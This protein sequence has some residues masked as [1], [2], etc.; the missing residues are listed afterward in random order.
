MKKALLFLFAASVVFAAGPKVPYTHEGFYSTDK[1]QK[2]VHFVS[3]ADMRQRNFFFFFF[4][5][6]DGIRDA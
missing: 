6:E 5:A 4:Q 1:V 3:V 2:A